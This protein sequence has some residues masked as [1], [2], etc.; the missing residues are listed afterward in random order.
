VS[1]TIGHRVVWALWLQGRDRSPRIV[2]ECL[3]S[4][5]R[6][7][8]TW[9]V[10][11]LDATTLGRYV[12]V[13]SVVD[14]A[15]STV[16]AASLSDIVRL[17]LLHEYG[18]V[19][20]DATLYCN[21]PL[22]DWLHP[23][24][25]EDLFAFSR[26]GPDRLVASW[27]L[28]AREPSDLVGTWMAAM[29]DYWRGRSRSD[30]YF[31]FHH[32]FGQLYDADPLFRSGWDRVPTVSADGPHA[33]LGDAAYEPLTERTDPV[34]WNV[35]VFKFTHRVEYA[36]VRPGSVLDR[37]GLSE[38]DPGS[39]PAPEPD[40]WTEP[41]PNPA[42]GRVLAGL[43]VST[44][45]LG[46]H[47]QILAAD[48]LQSGFGMVPDV[49][50]DRDGELVSC[51]GLES[52]RRP[53]PILLNG[54]FKWG[55]AQWPPSAGL[56]VVYLGFHIR[57][58]QAPYLVGEASLAHFREHGPVGCRDTY[59]RDLL[60]AHGVDAFVSNCLT[61]CL[62]R[63]LPDPDRQ[64]DIVVASRH[65]RLPGLVPA[66]LGPLRTV[67]HYTGSS[68]FEDNLARAMDLLDVYRTTARLVVTDLLHSALVAV[69]MGI[70]VVV[71]APSNDEEGQRSDRERFSSLAEMV[72]IHD[73]DAAG[74]V[75]WAGEHVPVGRL[76]R[77]LV[78]A[79][80]T[81][82]ARWGRTGG[83]GVG[84]WAA[85]GELPPPG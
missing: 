29:V 54:W 1:T 70:P 58:R 65:G 3:D 53:V 61:L 74:S 46:D 73:P 2:E 47:L 42:S 71:F 24:L 32:L 48:H 55:E 72:H 7:N 49:R 16:T 64:T 52:V 56:D 4:W 79:F 14:L 50:I 23:L 51:P 9:E 57:L 80:A 30:D 20:V 67:D 77:G 6:Q 27:F 13:T 37:L 75:D 82:S 68:D 69:A 25:V 60:L 81:L 39:A 62:P 19:W 38:A 76:K 12:D 36:R 59:T 11:C 44:D 83:G 85:A 8:P 40:P 21:R 17:M 78:E 34:D 35:P 31:W 18:G 22:D 33:F 10:R 41:A 5:E 28:A 43:K 66:G 15:T 26:P 63:R 45:N 84:P